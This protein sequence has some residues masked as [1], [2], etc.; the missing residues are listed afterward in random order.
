[1]RGCSGKTARKKEINAF[2]ARHPG[3][4]RN[5]L[6]HQ[7]LKSTRFQNAARRPN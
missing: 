6:L 5:T 2:L 7:Y 4:T 1:M 3:S